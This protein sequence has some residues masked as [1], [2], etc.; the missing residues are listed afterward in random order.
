MAVVIEGVL[1]FF[2]WFV[3]M[4][5]RYRHMQ[6]MAQE[7][8]LILHGRAAGMLSEYEEGDISILR[9]EIA[10]MTVMLRQQAEQLGD[11][12]HKLADALADI[13]HQIRTPLTSLNLMLEALK[14]RMTRKRKAA[15]YSI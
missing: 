15:L 11:E 2:L 7:I 13:S 12:K 3:D 5:R 4:Q 8:D 1:L 14:K 10:K 6:R 9:N